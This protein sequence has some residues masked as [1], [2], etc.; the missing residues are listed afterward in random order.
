MITILASLAFCL[1]IGSIYLLPRLTGK[2][3]PSGTVISVAFSAH[4]E[5]SKT[6]TDS[7]ILLKGLGVEGD[8]HCGAIVQHRSRLKIKP[9][10]PNLRQV[11]LIQSELFNE[12]N[13]VGPDGKSF[14]VRPADLGENVTTK[15]LELLSMGMDTKL[16]FVNPGPEETEEHAITSVTGLRNPCPRIHKFKEGLQEKCLVRGSDRGIVKRGAGVISV[17]QI[18]GIVMKGAKIVVE[19]NLQQIYRPV[20]PCFRVLI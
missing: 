14:D 17:V 18:G 11:H 13:Y 5:F 3:Q 12:F 1:L 15:G 10:S 16:H 20:M 7:I 8:C 19:K 2:P 4:H 9:A 6:P